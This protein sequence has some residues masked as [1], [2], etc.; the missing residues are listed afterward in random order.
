MTILKNGNQMPI[1]EFEK[2]KEYT[3][4]DF[5]QLVVLTVAGSHMY[6]MNTMNSDRDFL[7]IYMPTKEQLLLN[8]YPKQASYPKKSGLDLQIWSIHYFLK[9]AMAGETMA[10][11]LLHAPDELLVACQPDV[12]GY[13]Q[14]N[15]RMFFTKNMKAFVSYARKQ[16]AKYGLK[17]KRIESL[18][19]IIEYLNGVRE[20]TKLWEIWNGLPKGDHI[21]FLDIRPYRM[22]QVCGKK[23]QETVSVSYIKE[24]LQKS[25]TDY[26]YRAKLA[27]DNKG[28]DWKAVSHAM[29]SSDQVWEVLVNGDYEY[30]L[31]NANFLKDVKLGKLDFTTVVQPYLEKTMDGIEELILESDLPDKVDKKFWNEWLIFLMMEQLNMNWIW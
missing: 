31:K 17:G 22:Y 1:S 25:L 8:E 23:F 26:G 29:R 4:I 14:K 3:N 18:E 5:H 28:V 20:D 11:D 2:L 10:I 6:G 24:H 16:A 7:G 21:H 13:L 12:W 30:P 9:L 27:K 15:R 19:M